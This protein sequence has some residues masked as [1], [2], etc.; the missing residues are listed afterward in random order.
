VLGLPQDQ[1]TELVEETDSQGRV[2][3][4]RSGPL[5]GHARGARCWTGDARRAPARPAGQ[6]QGGDPRPFEVVGIPLPEPGYHVVE[7]ESRR[8]G[9][10]LLDKAAPMYVRT[11]VLVTN[12]GVHFKQGRENSAGVGDLARPRAAG[13]RRR[14]GGARL[15]GQALWAGRTD[16]S[17]VALAPQ[18][19]DS[20]RRCEGEGSIFVSARKTDDK[21]V[22]DMAF[23][24]A[25]WS[26]GIEPWRFNVPV[27]DDAQPDVR[28][29]TVFDRTLLRAGETV[30]MKHFVRREDR[31]GLAALPADELPTR[32]KIIHDGSG[33][34]FTQPLVW[35]GT[36]SASQQLEH[37]GRRAKLG[38]YRVELENPNVPREAAPR[39]PVG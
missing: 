13:G 23:V 39:W 31:Q 19:L 10:A 38:L 34:Q 26:K 7:I 12:L 5:R 15:P 24:F 28:A 27:S 37:P 20:T 8:L 17:G 4:R 9:Q 14:G 33:E 1:W 16:A 21:G 36:R 11:G 32:V 30:S 2:V 35:K 22:T 6:L 3:K 25:G 18:R 29:H